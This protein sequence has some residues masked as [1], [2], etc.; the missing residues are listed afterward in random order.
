MPTPRRGEKQKDFVSRCI[1]VVLKDGTAKGQDQAVAVCNSMWE[2]RNKEADVEETEEK[3]MEPEAVEEKMMGPSSHYLPFGVTT[4]AELKAA[5]DADEATMEVSGM[6]SDL[7]GLLGNRVSAIMMDEAVDDKAAAIVTGLEDLATELAGLVKEEA[8]M[9]DAEKEVEER[10]G[11][12][13]KE[14]LTGVIQGA[15]KARPM[16]TVDGKKYPSSDF[17]VVEDSQSPS[18]WHL[19]VRRNGTPNRGLAAAAWAALFAPG[20]H[21]GNKYAGPGKASAAKKLRALY[22]AQGW[23]TPSTGK[24]TGLMVW[25]EADGGYRWLARYSNNFRD[26]DNPPE[27]IAAKSHQR[28]ASMV[29]KGQVPLPELWLWHVP[30]WRWGKAAWAAYDDTGF[31]LA[32]GKVDKDK[33]PLAET[34][35]AIDPELI[36][37]S[38]G[39]PK[40]SIKRDPDDPTI[41]V[42]HV[43]REISPLPAWAAANSRTGFIM[44]KEATMAI[45]DEKRKTLQDEWGLPTELLDSLEAANAADAEEAKEAGIETKDKDTEEP[46]Q[47]QPAAEQETKPLTREELGEVVATIGQSLNVLTQQVQAVMGEVKELKETK[48]A[49]DEETLSDLF[50]RAIGHEQARLDGRSS[51][52]KSKPRETEAPEETQP[53][54]QTGQPLVDGIVND[55][56][57][58]RWR[59]NLGQQ[60]EA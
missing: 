1:P 9:E 42:E 26:E 47:D 17:L 24:E 41:I 52:A 45:P 30:G 34:I 28:F 59:E 49:E 38:H 51:L 2:D 33:G 7:Q 19:Q 29:D 22:K 39:M 46:A 31:A 35:M 48:A 21:R 18:T 4:F 8:Q 11:P 57:T 3:A 32:G 15:L 12:S 50:Q 56:V 54:I 36:R 16:K 43:T 10:D 23:E 14:W 44:S 58:G 5:R 25:K 27:I 53:I 55:L 60:Q 37:V 13:L 40:S 20:G 6:A